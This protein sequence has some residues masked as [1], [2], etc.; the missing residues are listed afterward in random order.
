METGG[1]HLDLLRA[2]LS[3]DDQGSPWKVTGEGLL[4]TQ[5]ASD[6]EG[7]GQC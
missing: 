7:T 3:R 6:A 5:R 4:F 2:E 1:A